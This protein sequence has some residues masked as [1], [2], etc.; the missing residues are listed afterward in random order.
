MVALLQAGLRFL[1]PFGVE[2]RVRDA[3]RRASLGD[4]VT[5]PALQLFDL[6]EQGFEFPLR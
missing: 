3:C 5:R 6:P 4:V 2:V 1:A